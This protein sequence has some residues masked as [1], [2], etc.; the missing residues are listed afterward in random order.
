MREYI[1]R[2][3]FVR[4]NAVH[5]VQFNRIRWQDSKNKVGFFRYNQKITYF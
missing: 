1:N 3:A 5:C 2:H 4:L